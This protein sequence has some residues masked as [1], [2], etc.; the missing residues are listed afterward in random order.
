LR[1]KIIGIYCQVRQLFSFAIIFVYNR[2]LII[3]SF[4]KGDSN[5]LAKLKILQADNAAA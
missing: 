1:Q 3:C 5:L 4:V 2:E